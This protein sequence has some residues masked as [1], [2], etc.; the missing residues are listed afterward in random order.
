MIAAMAVLAVASHV[1][2][3]NWNY[4]WNRFAAWGPAGNVTG[5][6]NEEQ[7][8]QFSKYSMVLFG[9]K[10]LQISANYRDLLTAQID[11]ARR[12]KA[13]LPHIPV[14]VYLPVVDAQPDTLPAEARLF[15]DP[16]YHN[17]LLRNSSGELAKHYKCYNPDNPRK[18]F[19]DPACVSALWNFYNRSAVN[20]YLEVIVRDVVSRDRH[21]AD[22]DGVF[23]DAATSFLAKAKKHLAC[24][25]TSPQRCAVA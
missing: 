16:A 23:F 17:F 15:H 5:L 25:P 3:P 2:L 9:W 11:Q 8:K 18:P 1:P 12:V 20:Y 7:L 14:F 13:R 22:F 4:S 21:E 19:H 10:D 24:V 6:E